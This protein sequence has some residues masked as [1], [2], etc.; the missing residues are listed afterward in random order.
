LGV[1]N[2]KKIALKKITVKEN[3]FQKDYIN[4]FINEINIIS[5][6]RHPNIVLYMG[7][8]IDKKNYYMITEYLPKGSLFDYIHRDRGKISE[9]EQINIAYEIAVALKYLHSRNVVHCDLKSSN[10]LI[11]DNWKIKIGDFGLSRFFS[12]EDNEESKGRIG[13][14]HWM[15]PEV[16][17]G[18]KYEHS[19]DIFSF[20]MILWEIISLE[21]PYYGIDPYQVISLVAEQKRIVTVPVKGNIVIRNLIKRCLDYDSNKRPLLDEIVDILDKAKNYNKLYDSNLE[22]LSDYLY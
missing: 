14:P 1:W 22:E 5:S 9:R 21:I 8:S 13:T 10:I 17:K 2:G 4:K 7:A 6:L 15:A 19:A 3:K 12:L 16:L 18:E 11:D 20:G